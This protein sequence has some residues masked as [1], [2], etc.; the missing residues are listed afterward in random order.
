LATEMNTLLFFMK[1]DQMKIILKL[2]QLPLII[3]QIL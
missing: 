3:H 2:K 1:K